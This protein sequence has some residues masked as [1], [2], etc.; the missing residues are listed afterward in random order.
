MNHP[1]KASPGLECEAVGP[2]KVQLL[3]EFGIVSTGGA[4]LE[5][6]GQAAVLIKRIALL[7]FAGIEQVVEWFWPDE[8]PSIGRRRLRNLLNRVNRQTNGVLLR[9]NGGLAI[10]PRFHCD[11]AVVK[12]DLAVLEAS[13][14]SSAKPKLAQ[15]EL[16]EIERR[17]LGLQLLIQQVLPHDR[18][19]DI[20]DE[21]KAVLS[22]R[23]LVLQRALSLIR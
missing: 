9:R 6:E 2:W 11:L 1:A 16:A 15:P 4:R 18:Y 14:V 20:V 23:V 3:S 7:G 12:V 5:F 17:L 21:V 8:A 13:L 10:A 22:R 19:D